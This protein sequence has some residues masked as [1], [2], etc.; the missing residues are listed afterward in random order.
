MSSQGLQLT[1][2]RAYRDLKDPLCVLTGMLSC[3]EV[4]SSSRVPGRLVE[5]CN[6]EEPGEISLLMAPAGYPALRNS[7][8]SS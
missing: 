8:Q 3:L 1:S 2:S 4:I 6:A 5:T 7:E